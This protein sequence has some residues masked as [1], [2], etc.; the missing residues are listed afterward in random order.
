MIRWCR[1]IL[2]IQR[3]QDQKV[4]QKMLKLNQK[5]IYLNSKKKD[6]KDKFLVKMQIVDQHQELG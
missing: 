5:D 4:K 2:K 1:L 6:I 3:L